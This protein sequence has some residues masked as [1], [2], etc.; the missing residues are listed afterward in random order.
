MSRDKEHT[1]IKAWCPSHMSSSTIRVRL[2]AKNLQQCFCPWCQ[3]RNCLEPSELYKSVTFKNVFVFFVRVRCTKIF[4]AILGKFGTNAF[5][6]QKMCLLLHL[7]I[8]DSC[9]DWNICP[10]L[11]MAPAKFK[12]APHQKKFEKFCP[13]PSRICRRLTRTQSAPTSPP[14]THP[15]RVVFLPNP[16]LPRCGR[17]PLNLFNVFLR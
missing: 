8:L 5:A 14:D 6:L 12:P 13:L 4:R 7:C 17:K 3:N 15:P 2:M 16:H 1:L 10:L 11:P 9:T